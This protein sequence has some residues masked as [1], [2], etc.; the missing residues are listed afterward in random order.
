MPIAQPLLKYWVHLNGGGLNTL[1]PTEGL[2][3]TEDLARGWDVVREN[4]TTLLKD[5]KD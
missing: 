3:S 1:I 4:T 2:F 5:L